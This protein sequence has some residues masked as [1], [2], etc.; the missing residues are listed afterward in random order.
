MPQ[1]YTARSYATGFYITSTKCDVPGQ[2]VAT[3]DGKGSTPEGA[4]LTFSQALQPAITDVSIQGLSGLY[5][6]LPEG[7]VSG[8]KLVWS[9]TPATWQVNTTQ[10]GLYVIVPKGQ[11]LYLY[12]GNDIGPIVQVKKGVEIRGQ[13]NHWTL[14][15]VD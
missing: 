8:S 2:I 13:E 11:D 3:A 12:T 15:K 14:T 5:I 7:A 10:T 6:T 9:S 4:T 1:N